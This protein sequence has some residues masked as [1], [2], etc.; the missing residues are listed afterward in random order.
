[1][2]SKNRKHLRII[3]F[4]LF[5]ILCNSEG[6]FANNLKEIVNLEGRWKFS[7]GDN[8]EWKNPNYNDDD[9][10]KIY[11]PQSWKQMVTAI[12]M[13]LPGIELNLNYRKTSLKRLFIYL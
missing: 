5:V 1:M 3:A 7:I 6:V 12:I 13:V 10:D 9:W 4:V 11:V 2:S 8:P